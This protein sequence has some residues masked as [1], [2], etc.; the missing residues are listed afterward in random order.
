LYVQ[1]LHGKPDIVFPGSRVVVFVDGDYWHCRVLV[2]EGIDALRARLRTPSRDYWLTKFQRRVVRDREV[3]ERLCEE[4]WLVV[5]LWE[6]DVK[7]DL[8]KTA[9]KI[10]AVVRRRRRRFGRP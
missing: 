6:S 10:A 9:R 1:G 4:G 5:R 2:E 3:T 7:R 8:D